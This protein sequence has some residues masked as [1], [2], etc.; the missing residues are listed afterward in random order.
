MVVANFAIYLFTV[1]TTGVK[2]TTTRVLREIVN[3]G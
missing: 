3:L 2:T 1:V